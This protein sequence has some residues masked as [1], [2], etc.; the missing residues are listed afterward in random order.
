M[1]EESANGRDSV[2]QRIAASVIGIFGIM[3]MTFN[4]TITGAVIGENTSISIGTIGMFI[5]FL[6]LLLF[7]R[8]LKKSF[9]N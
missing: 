8:P 5:V 9:K 3:L 7:L 2:F 6:A 1:V 4:L